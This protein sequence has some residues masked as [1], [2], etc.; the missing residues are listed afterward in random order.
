[1]AAHVHAELMAQYAEDA[2]ETP[3]PWCRWEYRTRGKIWADLSHNPRWDEA[4][5]Y[6]RKIVI[7]SSSLPKA[8][9]APLKPGTTYYVPSLTDSEK[10]LRSSWEDDSCDKERLKRGLVYLDETE[11][12]RCTEIILKLTEQ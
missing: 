9:V 12:A 4:T 6:R 1:M 11:A 5:I 10:F 7:Y 8:C 2:K 3:E